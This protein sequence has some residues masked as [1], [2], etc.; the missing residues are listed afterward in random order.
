M[1]KEAVTVVITATTA[2]S[3]SWSEKAE[4]ALTA[5]KIGVTQD[6]KTTNGDGN[7]TTGAVAATITNAKGSTLPST[8][9][10]GTTIFYVLGALLVVCGG[11][12]LVRRK[13]AAR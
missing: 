12:V 10:I 4:D 1:L 5:L 2:N 13:N 9:G 6:D 11:A 3:Q 7:T 8:G